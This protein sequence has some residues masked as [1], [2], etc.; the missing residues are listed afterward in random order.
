MG[1]YGQAVGP[2]AATLPH[3]FKAFPFD[4]TDRASPRVRVCDGYATSG[5]LYDQY[6]VKILVGFH[7]AAWLGE[8]CISQGQP[9]GVCSRAGKV[10]P[11]PSGTTLGVQPRA[12]RASLSNVVGPRPA[13]ERQV[14]DFLARLLE[15]VTRLI[16]PSLRCFEVDR[17]ARDAVKRARPI[18]SPWR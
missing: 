12:A 1:R 2:A 3:R 5:A 13:R 10:C 16:P 7:V 6:V 8:V 15:N 18:S 9:H 11:R 14:R 17:R 4:G